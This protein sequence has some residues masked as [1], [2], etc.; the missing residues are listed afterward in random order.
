MHLYLGCLFAPVLIFFAVS[1][2]WQLYR[3]NDDEKNGS[4][5]APRA[6]KVLSTVH[7][8]SHLPGKGE[9][10]YTPL[11]TFFVA[12]AVGLVTTT[13]LGVVMAYRLSA[14]AAGPTI[15]LAAG[16]A[17]PLVALWMYH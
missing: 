17:I 13:L 8:D 10:D 9:R 14:S 1:G 3:F 4:Y 15:C 6:I 11:R 16:V 2:A 7:K 12:A 5:V